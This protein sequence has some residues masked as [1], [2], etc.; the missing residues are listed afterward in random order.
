MLATLDRRTVR[1]R[2]DAFALS[3]HRHIAGRASEPAALNL[4]DLREVSAEYHDPDTGVPVGGGAA[5]TGEP[6]RGDLL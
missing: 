1:G 2:R 5:V 3:L 6:G 4:R